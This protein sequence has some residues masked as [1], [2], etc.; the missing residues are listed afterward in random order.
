MA[1]LAPDAAILVAESVV[2]TVDELTL[3][4]VPQDVEVTVV[5]GVVV[6]VVVE[7]AVVVLA[8]IGRMASC[9]GLYVPCWLVIIYSLH[10]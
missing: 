8:L 10:A 9:T 2:L 4:D 1:V 7:E 3:A 5:D 6:G